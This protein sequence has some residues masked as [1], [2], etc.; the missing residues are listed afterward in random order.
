[1]RWAVKKQLVIF[2]NSP[3]LSV[4]CQDVG[5]TEVFFCCFSDFY[6]QF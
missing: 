4:I 1:M 2:V 5:L 3:F 6:S